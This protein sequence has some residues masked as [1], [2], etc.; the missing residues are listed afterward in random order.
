[1]TLRFFVPILKFDFS[2]LQNR[3]MQLTIE[4]SSDLL[5]DGLSKEEL[6]LVNQLAQETIRR[7]LSRRSVRLR[8]KRLIPQPHLAREAARQSRLVSSRPDPEAE[9]WENDADITDW[10]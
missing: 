5:P 2:S 1:M 8:T 7:Y 10:Q 9:L 4:I 6:R 3:A